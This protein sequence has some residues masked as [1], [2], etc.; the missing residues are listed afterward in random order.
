MKEQKESRNKFV[1]KQL[2]LKSLKN[3]KL[4][5]LAKHNI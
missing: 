2:S 3:Y 4:N 1:L 5:G